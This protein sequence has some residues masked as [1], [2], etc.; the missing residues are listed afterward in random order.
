[1]TMTFLCLLLYLVLLERASAES[2]VKVVCPNDEQLRE[3]LQRKNDGDNLVVQCVNPW[4]STANLNLLTF[5]RSF[6]LA[7]T[8]LTR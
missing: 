1:M 8:K 5:F 4:M 3:M 6:L 2:V 7:E